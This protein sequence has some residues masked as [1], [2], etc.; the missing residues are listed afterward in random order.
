MTTS[1]EIRETRTLFGPCPCA[2][3]GYE[4]TI[5]INFSDVQIMPTRMID[6]YFVANDAADFDQL[7]VRSG[8]I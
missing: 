1:T 6:A 8:Q 7:A 5:D 3:L 4:I 2:V